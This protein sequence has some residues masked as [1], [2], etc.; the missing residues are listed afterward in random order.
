MN[1]R[2]LGTGAAMALAMS[3]LASSAWA[4]MVTVQ[5]T[6][7]IWLAGQAG[8]TAVHGFFGT[9]TAA[10]NGPVALTLTAPTLTFSATGSSSVDQFNFGGP[11]GSTFYTDQS[12]YSPSPWNGDY[13][14]PASALVGVFLDATTPTLSSVGGY[15]GPDFIPGAD[16]QVP[17]STGPGVYAPALGQIFIIGDGAGETFNA[18]TGAT[19]LFLATADSL[20]GSTGNVGALEVTFT[21]ATAVPEPASWAMMIGGFGLAGAALRRRRVAPAV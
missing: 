13:N 16:Y 19:R 5:A 12:G 18:P 3:A 2:D 17:G 10:A 11:N 15:T 8:A 6:D 20:G 9:D 7:D 1:I 4:G 14:G 21:G